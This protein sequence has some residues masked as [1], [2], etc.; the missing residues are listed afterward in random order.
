MEKIGLVNQCREYPVG[1]KTVILNNSKNIH[2]KKILFGNYVYIS[3]IDEDSSDSCSDSDDSDEK[4]YKKKV[5]IFL[6]K[7]KLIIHVCINL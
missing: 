2:G 5:R 4:I 3:D 7:K 6:K 1:D